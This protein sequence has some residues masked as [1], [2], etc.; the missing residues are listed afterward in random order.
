MQELL[1]DRIDRWAS[2]L[3][4]SI[5]IGV[6]VS[7]LDVLFGRVLLWLIATS[8]ELRPWIFLLLGPAGLIFMF[9]FLRYGKESVQGMNLVFKA[10][11]GEDVEIPKRLVIFVTVG[12]WITHF[13]GGS[14]GREGVAIQIG[15]TIGQ[16]F[17]SLSKRI[18]RREFVVIGM[19]AG[20]SG[21]FQTP[22]AAIFFALEVLVVG[23][24][25]YQ[26][27]IPT[28]VASFIAS[29][30]SHL[31]GLEKFHF[32]I[33]PDISI[34]P[35]VFVKI[36]ICGILFG[37]CG[38]LFAYL[39]KKGKQLTQRVI[40][41]P[42]L[43]IL[44]VGA[45]VGLLILLFFNGR[46][47]SLGMNLIEGTFS[48]EAIYRYDWLLKLLLTVITLSAGFQG[49]EVTPLFAIGTTLGV[50]LASVLGLPVLLIA[51]LGYASVFGSATN[52]ILAPIFIGAEVFGYETLPFFF[53][54]CAFSY[55]FNFNQSIYGQQKIAWLEK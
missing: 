54:A 52:T 17:G 51:A 10:G 42:M 14:A 30:L 41:S 31:L 44:I 1:K 4:I 43:R 25:R 22:I 18:D 38:A 53:I 26:V 49:G 32:E 19:A 47:A 3:F 40:P 45:L 46:Y 24:M 16:W 39:L 12:T 8:H 2:L 23:R 27:L 55:A 11:H 21:L 37:L 13:F 36:V 34:T 48:S 20:F 15:G 29:S 6:I 5:A 35:I 28:L 50:V 33:V 9:F 7:G